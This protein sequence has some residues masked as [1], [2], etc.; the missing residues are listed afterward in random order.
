MFALSLSPV[1]P[2]STLT[3]PPPMI[4]RATSLSPRQSVG[5]FPFGVPRGDGVWRGARPLGGR[6]LYSFR[7][8]SSSLFF[9][10]MASRASSRVS[11][12][13]RFSN[14]SGNFGTFFGS[15]C[16]SLLTL[17]LGG[18]TFVDSS[19]VGYVRYFWSFTDAFERDRSPR[20]LRSCWR[21]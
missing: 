19:F 2:L 15:R 10:T 21:P 3:P 8:T 17:H 13:L 20:L 18:R 12:L 5:P 6:F 4:L 16:R 1:F 9:L 7:C 11:F 14:G